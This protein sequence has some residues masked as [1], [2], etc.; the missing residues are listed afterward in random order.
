MVPGYD[1]EHLGLCVVIEIGVVARA[2]DVVAV[3]DQLLDRQIRGESV[4]IQAVGE[5]GVEGVVIGV[6]DEFQ[7][8]DER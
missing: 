2:V 4:D 1:R 8:V 7:E 6:V 5:S 3:G